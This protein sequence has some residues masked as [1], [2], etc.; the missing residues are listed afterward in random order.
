MAGSFDKSGIIEFF[1]VEASEHIQNLN[2]GLLALEKDP[3]NRE[4]IDELFRAAH[5]LKGSA[6][7]MG[8]QGISDVGH[9]AEDMLGLF[10]S[11]SIPITRDTL[12]FLFDSVDA[13]KLMV[14]GIASKKPEDPL[15]I[16][17]ITQSFAT[18]V[19]TLRG[20]A[21]PSPAPGAATAEKSTPAAALP[22]S[23]VP[24]SAPPAAKAPEKPASLPSKEELDIAWE[25]AFAEEAGESPKP[26]KAAIPKTPVT[27]PKKAVSPKPATTAPPPPAPPSPV[28]P[29]PTAAQQAAADA[30]AMEAAAEASLQ[31]EIE[32]SKRAGVVEKR[33]IGRRAADAPD[34]EKQFIRVNI[35]RLDNLMNLVGEMVVNRNKLTRQVNLIKSLRDELTFSQNRLLFEIRKFEEKYEYT[36]N[37]QAPSP[38]PASPEQLP[39]EQSGDFFEL[40]FDRYDDFNLLSR[41]LTEITNDTN[42]IMMEFSGFFDSFE[43]DTSRISTITSNLQNEITMAR[44][45]EMD[46]LFQ[47]FQ[48]PVRDMA[49]SESKKIN[50][51]VTGGDTKIDKTIFEIISDPLMHMVRNAISHGIEGPEERTRNGKDA[52][53][54]L[55]LS[56][57]H[58][59]S[60]IVLQIEDDGRGMDPEQLRRTAVEKRFITEGEAKSMSD[61][62]ALNLIFRAGFS[63]ASAV[64]RVSGRGVGMDV[65]TNQLGKINGRIEIKTEKNVGTRF[66][67]RLP[68]T[69]AIAQALIIKV[70]DQEIAIPMNLVEETTRFSDKDIQRAAGE[71]MVNL[72]GTLMRLMRLNTL[73]AAGKTSKKAEDY[74]YP[75]LILVLAEKRVA[76]MVEDIVGREEIVVKSLGEY[77]KNVRMFSGASISGE[78]DV[79]LILNVAHLF[80]EETISTKTS[81]IGGRETAA[82]DTAR[83]KPRILVVDDSISIRKYVQRFLDRSGYE[84]ETATD[85]M[86]A[87][88]VLG[89]TMVD[90]VVTDLEMPVM[91]G[92]DLMAEMKRNPVFM[93]IPIIVLTSRAGEKH[94]QKAIDMGAQDYLVKPFE[95]QEMI[96]ALKKLL[97]SAALASR[98]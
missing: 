37:F 42:E 54:V 76:L 81:Y 48:R 93:N 47:L 86:N 45:V 4:V 20:G 5:T 3:T 49:Q 28:P 30:A 63:T 68:L 24:V 89:K 51:V 77:L 41:K 78:G 9:K 31:K 90:A 14:D 59:G 84:V 50:M 88:E 23:P 19:D 22:A 82:A 43:L 38:A 94:R 40:E 27:A 69:L 98:A 67:I 10:R 34:I 8:F 87:L 13:V 32:D 97:S 65:V 15:I 95:E 1:L 33:G 58:D 46:R 6:A 29:R 91:H 64:G 62:D 79:R 57:R 96:E 12:N 25:N 85:G 18:L 55:I 70:K 39:A 21:A 53:G 74:R 16:E 73:L 61:A 80:G 92:Y 7:M 52:S 2:A 75:T 36:M 72:R 26:G 66:I 11:G 17:N 83:R 35:E 71:E 56:A 44:M 60:S